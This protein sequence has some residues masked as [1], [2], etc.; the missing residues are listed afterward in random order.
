MRTHVFSLQITL[1]GNFF[2]FFFLN[3][4]YSN[5]SVVLKKNKLEKSST[6]I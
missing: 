4:K 3:T 6:E 5:H 1:K 2:F